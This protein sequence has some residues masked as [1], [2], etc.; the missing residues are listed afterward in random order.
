MTDKTGLRYDKGKS[1]VDLLPADA[2]LELGEVCAYGAHKYSERNW[3]KGMKWTK[4]IGP[5]LRHLYKWMIGYTVDK[6]SGQRHIAMVAWNA[7]A[8]L[9]Y[10]LRGIGEDDRGLETYREGDDLGDTKHH[11]FYRQKCPGHDLPCHVCE[12]D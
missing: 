5:L 10:E 4:V 3:E 2:M 6:E 8:L 7:I 1:R 11:D 12:T 9:T